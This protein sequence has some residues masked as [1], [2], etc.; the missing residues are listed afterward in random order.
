MSDQPHPNPDEREQ[1]SSVKLSLNAKRET[2]VEV[3]VYAGETQE[4]V[5]QLRALAVRTYLDT[6]R[7]VGIAAGSA[8]A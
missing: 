8:A 7:D 2:Q 1:R 4:E 6:M 3:K 5:D